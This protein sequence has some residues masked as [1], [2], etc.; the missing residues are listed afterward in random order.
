MDANLRLIDMDSN[1]SSASILP[2]DHP[3]TITKLRTDKRQRW[4]EWMAV[5]GDGWRWM[6]VDDGGMFGHMERS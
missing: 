4:Y 5:D 3:I 2:S 6:G 1:V